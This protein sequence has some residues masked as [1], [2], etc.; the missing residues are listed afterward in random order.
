MKTKLILGL[1]A[2]LMMITEPLFAACHDISCQPR[3]S[4]ISTLIHMKITD[5]QKHDIAVILMKHKEEFQPVLASIRVELPKLFQTITSD[6]PD[7]KDV[8]DAYRKLSASG[9][10]FILLA[11]DVFSEIKEEL[12]PEQR[13]IFKERQQQVNKAI[14]CKIQSR[15][16]LL[17]EWVNV[18]AQ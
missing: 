6:S 11:M 10:N 13:R 9:E 3:L 12:N 5:D 8:L 15:R 17:N 7:E 1:L 4:L 14:M 16:S 2:G 18:H